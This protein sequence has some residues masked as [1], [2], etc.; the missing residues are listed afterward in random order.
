MKHLVIFLNYCKSRLDHPV[1]RQFTNEAPSQRRT[2]LLF[3]NRPLEER[4]LLH[5]VADL[6]KKEKQPSDI[7]FHLCSG[8]DRP[9]D[10]EN[11]VQT[12]KM[13]RRLFPAKEGYRYPSYVYS[14][15]PGMED[16]PSAQKRII[17]DNLACL[18]NAVA[19]YSGFLLTN[20]IFLYNDP[21]QQSLAEYL[22]NIIQTEILPIRDIPLPEADTEWP[23]IFATFN[24]A[25]VNYPEMEVRDYL[26][27]VTLVNI[28]RCSQSDSNPTPI[29]VCNDEAKRILSQ[30]PIQPQRIS[31]Q[32]DAFLTFDEK[33]KPWTPVP[34]Y[35]Q[36]TCEEQSTNLNDIPHEDW[37][38][39]IRQ[40]AEVQFQ[41]RFRDIGVAYFFQL[42][43]KKSSLYAEALQRILQEEIDRTMQQKGYTPDTQKTII[44]SLV[45]M[46]QQRVIE[47]QKLYEDTQVEILAQEDQLKSIRD[48][49][50]G[51]SIF[52]RMMGKDKGILTSFIDTLATLFAKRTLAPGC[53]FGI[54]VLNE[55]IPVISAVVDK[56]D[57]SMHII[58]EALAAASIS[59]E[60][61]DPSALLGTISRP[62]VES[63]VQVLAEDKAFLL[64]CYAEVARMF[65]DKT[66]VVAADDLLTRLRSTFTAEIDQHIAHLIDYGKLPPVIGLAITERM[67]QHYAD[68]GGLQGF[69]QQLKEHTPL[70]LKLK[71]DNIAD[72]YLLITPTETSD[73]EIEHILTDNLS[74]IQ[75]LHLK[76]GI[77]LTDL[78]GFSGQKMFVEPSLF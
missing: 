28:L 74:H 54:K 17:W 23:P 46:L 77:R 26:R 65:F 55:L 27:K 8:L 9:T 47:L 68:R 7:C 73:T 29:E 62:Q 51:L 20:G 67:R 38:I 40:R 13:I 16:C 25:G 57:Q 34:E 19:S 43:G 14:Q 22:F 53:Q 45:N 41:S 60:E 1:Y 21:S 76:Q 30:I 78:D 15:L 48:K 58:T 6:R 56:S 18:N 36:R 3:Q 52:S 24:A 32:E 44:R 31:L 59:A 10:G 12:L 39:K 72:Q 4:E 70:S 75:L 66:P 5:E 71:T 61:A 35:W 50:N 69:L 2:T 63:A 42:Q 33:E 11:I 64:R 49:W 37:L